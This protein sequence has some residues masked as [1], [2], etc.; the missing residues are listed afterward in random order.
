FNYSDILKPDR[1]C[2]RL[3]AS[4]RV[5]SL[6]DDGSGYVMHHLHELLTVRSER[7]PHLK[8][9]KVQVPDKELWIESNTAKVPFAGA[10][11]DF[12]IN[13]MVKAGQANMTFF[14]GWILGE[15]RGT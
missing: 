1:F 10:D 7:F 5:L 9:I 6:E 8:T 3:P 13:D 15:E 4:L 12:T 14:E 11:I 2:N